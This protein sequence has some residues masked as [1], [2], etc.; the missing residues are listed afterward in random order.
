MGMY[1]KDKSKGKTK[2]EILKVSALFFAW[3]YRKP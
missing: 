1:R 3:V 2:R